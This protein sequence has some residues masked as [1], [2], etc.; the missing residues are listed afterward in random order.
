MGG[1]LQCV[2]QDPA[3]YI[4]CLI[5]LQ[6]PSPTGQDGGENSFQDFASIHLPTTSVSYVICNMVPRVKGENLD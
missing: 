1:G 4:L 5:S 3:E 6:T 2:V